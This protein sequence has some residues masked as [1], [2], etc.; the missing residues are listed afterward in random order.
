MCQN[1]IYAGHF[2]TS[3]HNT[4]NWTTEVRLWDKVGLGLPRAR[5][6]CY[7]SSSQ[8][9]HQHHQQSKVK[10]RLTGVALKE[11]FLM[12]L[13]CLVSMT[14]NWVTAVTDGEK[15]ININIDRR[16]ELNTAFTEKDNIWEKANCD[17][18]YW[19]LVKYTDLY[20]SISIVQKRE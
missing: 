3:Q 13:F 6:N 12:C 16:K 7:L 20:G 4:Q 8:D 10:N 14:L 15:K 18:Y 19:E 5:R 9:Q 17:L 1:Y 2:T 11:M